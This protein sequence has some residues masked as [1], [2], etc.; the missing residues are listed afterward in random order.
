MQK[1][2]ELKDRVDADILKA[3]TEIVVFVFR[4]GIDVGMDAAR[5][6]GMGV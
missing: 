3:V 5:K 4:D 1:I 2:I 6:E